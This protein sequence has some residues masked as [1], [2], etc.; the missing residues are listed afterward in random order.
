MRSLKGIREGGADD[1]EAAASNLRMTWRLGCYRDSCILEPREQ[2]RTKRGGWTKGRAVSLERLYLHADAFDYLSPQDH[3]IC[4]RIEAETVYEY[5]GR[6]PKTVYSLE[7]DQALLEAMGH[8]LLFWANDPDQ[9]VELVQGDPVLEVHRRKT[10]LQLRLVPYPAPHSNLLPQLEGDRRVRLVAFNAQHRRIAEILDES[11]LTVPLNAKD[12][13]LESIAAIAPL[14]TIHSDIGAGTETKA[15]P[16]EADPR[17]H[18]HLRP[19]GEGLALEYYIQPFG[20]AGPLFHPG[21][22][23]TTLF[24][25]IGGKSLQTTRD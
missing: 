12:Q 10:G 9:A 16:T 3:R 14:L 4:Q 17:P 5:F 24:A 18:I 20:E 19:A 2:K 1:T 25:E 13:V 6:Y 7:S 22:G 8:P 11:G 21:Q 23:R 15:I